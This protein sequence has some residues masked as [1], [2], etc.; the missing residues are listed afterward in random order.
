MVTL[1]PNIIIPNNYSLC[2]LDSF[3]FN[4]YKFFLNILK[5]IWISKDTKQR[6]KCV[7]ARSL[8]L[9]LLFWPLEVLL[10]LEILG[11]LFRPSLVL[12]GKRLILGLHL[13]LLNPG[14]PG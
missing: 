8:Q 7:Q 3:Q 10:L 9:L 13:A 11:L 14:E 1:L 5:S 4:F 12:H 6:M 2:M